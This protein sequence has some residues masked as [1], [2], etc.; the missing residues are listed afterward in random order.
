VLAQRYNI[1]YTATGIG[2]GMAVAEFQGQDIDVNDL[3][4]FQQLCGLKQQ[5]VTKIVGPNQPDTGVESGLDIEYIMGVAP[6]IPATFW[7][8]AQYSLY[9]WIEQVAGAPNPPLV[10]RVS[11]GNDEEQNGDSY[12]EK[13]NVE[14]AKMASRGISVLFASGDQGVWGRTGLF[15]FHPD[16][17][18]ASPYITS[19][20]ATQFPGADIAPEICTDWSGGGFSRH[21]PPLNF[22]VAAIQNYFKVNAAQLPPDVLW[23]RTGNGYPTLSANGG[24]NQAYCVIIGGGAEGVA[25]TSASCPT[26]AAM[27][28]LL[29]DRRL[30]A[31]KAPLGFL[32]PLVFTMLVQ[33]PSAFGDIVSGRNSDGEY[34][35][36]DAVPGW[37]PC[38]GAGNINFSAWLSYTDRL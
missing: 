24:N 34:F 17:P 5:N 2:S 21:F 13:T 12:M 23:N 25:G 38:S 28:S 6:N 19:V 35:G 8:L 20:G 37:D 29:N 1:T 33:H 26:A 4:T 15:E 3:F 27:I 18:A 9:D 32:N 31:K 7:S 16:F 14:F 11:Y 30:N 22:S 36:F 10:H